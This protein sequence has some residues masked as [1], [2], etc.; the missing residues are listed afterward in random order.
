MHLTETCDA[1]APH[2][3]VEVMTTTATLPDGEVVGD[4]HEHLE[5][6]D[7]LPGQHLV[8]TGSVDARILAESQHRSHVD[9]FGPV[10]PDLTWQTRDQRGFDHRPFSVFGGLAGPSGDLPGGSAQSELGDHS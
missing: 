7:L 2:L 5:K 1:D 9:L 6:P 4:L 3:I 10:M 8:D